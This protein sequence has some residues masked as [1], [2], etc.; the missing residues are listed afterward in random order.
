MK[1]EPASTRDAK[2]QYRRKHRDVP[3]SKLARRAKVDGI[4]H[5]ST[6]L[7]DIKRVFRLIDDLPDSIQTVMIPPRRSW[8]FI[9]HSAR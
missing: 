8:G 3:I 5:P 2:I 9:R 1:K 7:C 6:S 4:Y